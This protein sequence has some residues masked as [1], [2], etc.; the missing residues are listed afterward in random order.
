MFEGGCLF[1]MGLF[2]SFLSCP[3]SPW[4]MVRNIADNSLAAVGDVDVLNH[5][6]LLTAGAISFQSFDL[7]GKGAGQLVE[8]SLCTVLLRYVV[9]MRK[10]SRERHGSPVG[11]G[12]ITPSDLFSL[13][14][15]L[16]LLGVGGLI[17]SGIGGL[18]G[19]V[20]GSG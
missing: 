15:K 1:C 9:D 13:S 5:D 11:G 2:L 19:G 10:T 17:F 4:R 3:P 12:I 16:S 18:V 8:R 14:L 7:R 20:S 6:S